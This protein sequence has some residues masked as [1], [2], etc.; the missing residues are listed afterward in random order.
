MQHW[1]TINEPWVAA[2]LG[3][4]TGDHAPGKRDFRLALL[5]AHTLL[6]AHG[7]GMA[8]LRSELS[9]GGQA[10][11]ALNLAPCQPAG[12]TNAD[13]EAA[14]RIDGFTNRWFLDALYHGRV[15]EDMVRLYG[16]A[17]PEIAPGDMELISQ[18]PTSSA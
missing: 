6:V 18:R 7:E 3:H 4:W 5:V 17:M 14:D 11:I 9:S 12:D 1:I 8:A 10:G 15:P 16:D 13:L 2:F